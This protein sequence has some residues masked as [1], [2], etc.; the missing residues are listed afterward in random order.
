MSNHDIHHLIS[1]L[2]NQQQRGDVLVVHQTPVRPGRSHSLLQIGAVDAVVAE[3]FGVE[4]AAV[5]VRCDWNRPMSRVST[6]LTRLT[7]LPV[8]PN[9]PIVRP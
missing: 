8:V 6:L 4:V 2:P 7:L 3:E 1:Q 5:A 9:R